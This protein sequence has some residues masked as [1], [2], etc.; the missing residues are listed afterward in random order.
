M[1]CHMHTNLK[2]RERLIINHNVIL[3]LDEARS[4]RNKAGRRAEER[5][6]ERAMEG[7]GEN[8]EA[9]RSPADAA[10]AAGAAPL[11]AGGGWGLFAT[12]AATAVVRI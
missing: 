2:A 3:T 12:P 8:H 10:D 1:C 5:E 7:E 11:T 4:R 6:R 9:G